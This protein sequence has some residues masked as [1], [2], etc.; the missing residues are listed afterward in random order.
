MGF[1]IRLC[2]D[3]KLGCLIYTSLFPPPTHRAPRFSG[4]VRSWR[5]RIAGAPNVF[6]P[7]PESQQIIQSDSGGEADSVPKGDI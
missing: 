6:F 5:A 4:H 1:Y 3:W 7:L 2:K